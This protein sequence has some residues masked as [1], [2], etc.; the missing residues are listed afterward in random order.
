MEI[1]VFQKILLKGE[2]KNQDKINT[3]FL[4]K[5]SNPLIFVMKT[6]SVPAEAIIK[7]FKY[8]V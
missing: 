6:A 1:M 7:Y 3:F 2:H 5:Y 4:K 8:V